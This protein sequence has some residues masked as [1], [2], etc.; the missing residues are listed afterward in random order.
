MERLIRDGRAIAYDDAG[1]GGPPIVLLHGLGCT[2]QHQKPLLDHFRATNRVVSIDF[3]GHGESDPHDGS[4]TFEGYVDDVLWVCRELG[5]H[6][7]V[8]VGHSMGGDI[9]IAIGA[10]P[11]VVSAVVMLDSPFLVPNESLPMILPLFNALGTDQFRPA[12]RAFTDASLGPF[13]G[14]ALRAQIHEDAERTSEAVLSALLSQLGQAMQA[15]VDV[16]QAT[17]CKV[18]VL[19]IDY[20]TPDCDLARFASLCPQL[21]VAKTVGTGHWGHLEA[22]EQVSPMIAR[23]VQ[24]AAPVAAIA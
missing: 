12:F 15:H 3:A 4:E 22:P 13:A 8:L 5:I 23:F 16:A 11:E 14:Q 24:I 1:S 9:A 19:Y 2:R 7:P 18:P 21:V 17:A 20:G 10:D 6:R